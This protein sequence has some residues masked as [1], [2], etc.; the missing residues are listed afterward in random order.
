MAEGH[1]H[2]TI[3]PPGCGK[4][5]WL[6][7]QVERAYEK[8]RNITVISLTRSSAA[9]VAGRELPIPDRQVG[10][11][12]SQCF[13]ALRG[14]EIAETPKHADV[15]NKENP[16]YRITPVGDDDGEAPPGER[17]RPG[18]RPPPQRIQDTPWQDGTPPELAR[19]CRGLRQP[20]GTAQEG[21]GR[22][23]LH[24]PHRDLPQGHRPSPGGA[25]RHH[26]RRGPGHG[27][28]R[29]GPHQEMGAVR[30]IPGRGRRSRPVPTA[31]HHRPDNDR[32]GPHRGHKPL[33]TR[34][35]IL[36]PGLR[37]RRQNPNGLPHRNRIAPLQRTPADRDR[38]RPQQPMHPRP[39][40]DRQ[41]SRSQQPDSLAGTPRRT[42]DR[43]CLKP[44]RVQP[45]GTQPEGESEGLG[46]RR[47][48]IDGT[49]QRR[50]NRHKPA[51][52]RR[53]P[54]AHHTRPIRSEPGPPTAG[55]PLPRVLETG[56]PLA[57]PGLQ[58][59]APRHEPAGP[60][61]HGPGNLGADKP[62]PHSPLP[63]NRTQPA[64]RT[65]Q[66]LR[67]RRHPDPQLP[68]RMAGL[69]SPGPHEPGRGREH[70][71]GPQPELPSLP[72]GPRQGDGLDQPLPRPGTPSNTVPPRS[73]A[74]S[75]IWR[76]AGSDPKTSSTTPSVTS[77][78]ARRS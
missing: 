60:R 51:H 24:R 23:R 35:D 13:R 70:P 72:E 38:R 40:L 44:H 42:L 74:R 69:R 25:R 61:S 78:K 58:S 36:E 21:P 28:P 39:H 49:G 2:I 53:H 34:P 57:D 47:T 56:H 30:R 19:R 15:W 66:D 10:T 75:A 50:G 12:H 11:L 1:H 18:G 33:R 4:T 5:T 7:R 6:S 37:P 45:T 59:P 16:H 17:G 68:L 67:R 48:G 29:D 9:E 41:N 52:R 8:S 55:P 20:L 27:P 62:H 73:R 65:P 76:H 64:G 54:A 14:A 46:P 22:P 31:R 43:L 71:P 77:T 63:G 3:G 32:P 26:G